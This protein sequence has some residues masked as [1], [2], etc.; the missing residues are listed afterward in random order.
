M[1]CIVYERGVLMEK[2][3]GQRFKE[4]REKAGLTQEELAE[5]AG[6]HSNYISRI[7][8]GESFPRLEAL[9]VLL[10]T[11][12]ISADAVLCD[13]VF[14]SSLYTENLLSKKLKDLPKKERMK[15]LEVVSLLVSQYEK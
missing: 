10:N 5:K 2:K 14:S 9:V 4:Y 13:L 8:R 15:I 11:L 3:V 12:D 6:L 1:K 7:E